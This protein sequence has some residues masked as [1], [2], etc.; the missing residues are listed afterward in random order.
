MNK[1]VSLAHL[2]PGDKALVLLVRG[3][4]AIARRLMEMGIVP[5]TPIQVIKKAPL[6][7]PLEIRVRDY[8]LALRQNEAHTIIV[9][10]FGD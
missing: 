8:H 7:D 1:E 4:G 9:S 3:T 6:G 10:Q 2:L 5:G